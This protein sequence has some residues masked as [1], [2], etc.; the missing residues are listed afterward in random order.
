M[1]CS[2][3]QPGHGTGTRT[4]FAS[5]AAS[6]SQYCTFIVDSTGAD[7]DEAWGHTRKG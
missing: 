5:S 1:K 6:S 2:V 4:F 3:P 7:W